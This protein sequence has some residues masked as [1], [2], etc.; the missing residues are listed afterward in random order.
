LTGFRLPESVQ[1]AH[2]IFA[3]C[4]VAD[5]FKG[6]GSLFEGYGREAA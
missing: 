6:V 5:L 3:V 4:F 2:D 1:D